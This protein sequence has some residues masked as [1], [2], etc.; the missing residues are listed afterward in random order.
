MRRALTFAAMILFLLPAC[1]GEKED[2][3]IYDAK[4]L[5]ALRK[6]LLSDPSNPAYQKLLRQADAL[7]DSIPIPVTITFFMSISLK[8]LNSLNS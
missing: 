4:D 1:S 3:L 6:D 7:L 8:F 2:F 5:S